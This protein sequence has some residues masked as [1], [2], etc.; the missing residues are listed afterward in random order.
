MTIQGRCKKTKMKC[1]MFGKDHYARNC[2]Q[3]KGNNYLN[4]KDYLTR[5]LQANVI[6]T[7]TRE[8]GTSEKLVITNTQVNFIYSSEIKP[9]VLFC[10]TINL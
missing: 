2:R 1:Y 6:T 4:R 8:V 7:S 9:C 5:N 10:K 3:R